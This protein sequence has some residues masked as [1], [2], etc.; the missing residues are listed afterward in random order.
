MFCVVFPPVLETVLSAVL[1]SDF[2]SVCCGLM[3]VP[4]CLVGS[5]FYNAF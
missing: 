5:L 2:G 3:Y 1:G 4:G